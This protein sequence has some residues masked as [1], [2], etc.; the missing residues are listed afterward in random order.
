MV[1]LKDLVLVQYHFVLLCV[2]RGEFLARDGLL[3][4]S[5]QVR[6]EDH[7]VLA[8]DEDEGAQRSRC[9]ATEGKDHEAVFSRLATGRGVQSGSACGRE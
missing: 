9:Q 2:G 3:L 7:P 1:V 8:P 6:T 4:R 5:A